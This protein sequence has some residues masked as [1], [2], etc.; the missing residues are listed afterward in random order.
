MFSIPMRGNEVPMALP[1]LRH[2][3]FSIPMRGNEVIAAPDDDA[4]RREVF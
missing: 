1:I 3:M 2:A 4:E